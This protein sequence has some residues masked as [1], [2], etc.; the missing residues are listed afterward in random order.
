[1][2]FGIGGGIGP[3]R[4]GISTKGIGGGIGPFSAGGSWR[5]R[6]RAWEGSP[7]Q[8]VA[9]LLALVFV[10][11][12]V[13]ALVFVVGAY[14]W[15]VVVVAGGVVIA[16]RVKS[17]SVVLAVGILIP[18]FYVSTIAI[19]YWKWITRWLFLSHDIPNVACTPSHVRDFRYD[20]PTY[21]TASSAI[22]QLRQKGFRH[23]RVDGPTTIP[24]GDFCW[25]NSTTPAVGTRTEERSVVTIH[26]RCE[27]LNSN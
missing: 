4:L 11:L 19:P 16:Q 8:L 24:R 25:V 15:P 3:I 2:R 26:I 27:G 21:C 7:T 23:V 17:K 18:V 12:A 14:A 1:M 13:I 10:V 22:T 9:R 5:G 6:R 20:D